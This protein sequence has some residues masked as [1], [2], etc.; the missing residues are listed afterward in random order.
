MSLWNGSP[1]VRNSSRRS[2]SRPVDLITFVLGKWS[3][4]DFLFFFFTVV[5][6]SPLTSF[7]LWTPLDLGINLPVLVGTLTPPL[8]SSSA[9]VVWE[10]EGGRLEENTGITGSGYPS[11]SR[12]TD[13]SV[14]GASPRVA[15]HP[16]SLTIHIDL[17]VLSLDC[18]PGP[19][20]VRNRHYKPKVRSFYVILL[21]LLPLS[22]SPFLS[23]VFSVLS[24]LSVYLF[25][26]VRLLHARTS[27]VTNDTLAVSLQ[28]GSPNPSVH[29]EG[30]LLR[31]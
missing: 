13:S 8:P 21:P 17:S 31:W 23:S 6:G 25:V 27:F 14:W 4:P 3:G 9:Y 15:W 5:S 16:H 28:G 20:T 12:F 26:N 19:P 29:S 24:L 7:S 1:S 22:L 2:M 18:A 10:R 30:L 11:T